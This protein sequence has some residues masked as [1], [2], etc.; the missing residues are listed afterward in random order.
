MMVMEKGVQ[1]VI[2]RMGMCTKQR[3]IMMVVRLEITVKRMGMVVV[4][5]VR[6]IFTKLTNDQKIFGTEFHSNFTAILQ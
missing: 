4:K 3:M 5:I 2:N 6:M 1:L